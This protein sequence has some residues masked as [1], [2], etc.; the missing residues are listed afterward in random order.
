MAR[1]IGLEVGP[2]AT[3]GWGVSGGEH[4][5]PRATGRRLGAG[6][7]LLAAALAGAHVPADAAPRKAARYRAVVLPLHAEALND[8]GLVVGYVG[9]ESDSRAATWRGR[10]LSVLPLPRG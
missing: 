3:E 4:M 7:A 1:T 9:P 10:R 8:H 5:R 2:I 6:V